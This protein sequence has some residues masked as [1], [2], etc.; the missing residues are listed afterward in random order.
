VFANAVHAV[1]RF[2][3]RDRAA[4]LTSDAANALHVSLSAALAMHM[5]TW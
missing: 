1:L 3:L 2:A 5:L 4:L